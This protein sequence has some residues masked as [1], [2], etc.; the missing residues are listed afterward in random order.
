[1]G[2]TTDGSW[3]TIPHRL[4]AHTGMKRQIRL[5]SSAAT[6]TGDTAAIARPARNF[7]VPLSIARPGL[8]MRRLSWCRGILPRHYL[9]LLIGSHL[10]RLIEEPYPI[11]F[12]VHACRSIPVTAPPSCHEDTESH[13]T[14]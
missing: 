6:A 14:A 1:M 2:T 10:P 11:P 4:E 5:R 9:P 13:D 3:S 7:R 12:R 8:R